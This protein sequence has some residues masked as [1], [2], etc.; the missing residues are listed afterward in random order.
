MHPTGSAAFHGSSATPHPTHPVASSVGRRGVVTPKPV[1]VP[2][3]TTT[4]TKS[5][6]TFLT[7]ED[8]GYEI[9]PVTFIGPAF[10]DGPNVTLKGTVEVSWYLVVYALSL[11]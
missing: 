1:V 3:N 4:T 2:G 10:V 9:S 11:Y 5:N 6:N 8:Y 7:L